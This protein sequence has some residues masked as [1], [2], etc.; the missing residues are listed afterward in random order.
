MCTFTFAFI[1]FNIRLGNIMVKECT[2]ELEPPGGSKKKRKHKIRKKKTRDVV[3]STRSENS[4]NINF[5]LDIYY[6]YTSVHNKLHH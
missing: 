5:L 2:T 6:T 4:E 1:F 3:Q